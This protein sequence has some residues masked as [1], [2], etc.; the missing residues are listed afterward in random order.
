MNRLR[1]V[2]F[3]A[4]CILILGCILI[5]KGL[6][7]SP[8]SSVV[9]NVCKETSQLEGRNY[10][11]FPKPK[12]SSVIDASFQ[13]DFEQA[14][15]DSTPLRDQALLLNANF[16][17]TSITCAN[18]VF[19][20]SCYPTFYGSRYTYVPSHDAVVQTL[21]TASP[22]YLQSM[23]R[24]AASINALANSHEDVSFYLLALDR[25]DASDANP[26]MDYVSNPLTYATVDEN[27]YSKLSPA[28][29]V[30]RHPYLNE[31]DLFSSLYRTDHHWH[32]S[33]AYDRYAEQVVLMNPEA[34]PAEVEKRVSYDNIDFFGACARTGL[35]KPQI[36]DHVDDVVI[37][38]SDFVVTLNGT[39]YAGDMLAHNEAFLNG[40]VN[41]DVFTNRYA[42]LFHGDWG[43]WQIDNPTAQTD[44]SL[45]IVRDSYG[46]CTERFYAA[47][48][49]HV[50]VIDFR[51]TDLTA[52]QL[53]AEHPDISDVLILMGW[54]NITSEAGIKGLTP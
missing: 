44:R 14:V 42:E 40:N 41:D 28:I 52:S 26:T 22:N 39:E 4:I 13:S 50:Y 3:S 5:A 18:Q 31:D 25:P 35:C 53:L 6:E 8:F 24:A 38:M 48:Y 15:A 54:N 17:R 9:A 20:Y 2:I 45:L 34:T 49:S 33:T 27:L 7:H 37:D 1:S 46:G 19:G 10:E 12:L 43:L 51:H 29:T 21:N 11:Y 30:S 36:P 47:N 32:T 16:Q 23:E